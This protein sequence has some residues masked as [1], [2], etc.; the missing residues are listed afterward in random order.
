M[1]QDP[2]SPPNDRRPGRVEPAELH[3]YFERYQ[4]EVIVLNIG[5]GKVV[6]ELAAHGWVLVHLDD[7]Y[8]IM[9]RQKLAQGMPIY[10]LIQALGECPGGP[11]QCD[12]RPGR[13]GA[14]TPELSQ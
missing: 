4:V 5:A 3:A 7:S 14:S 11:R 6:P 10:K 12:S 2:C 9:V 1:C 8:F 13:G